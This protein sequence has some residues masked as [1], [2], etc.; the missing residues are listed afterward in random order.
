MILWDSINLVTN[1]GIK[2]GNRY[3]G[4][5]RLPAGKKFLVGEFDGDI[6]SIP[7]LTT[8]QAGLIQL[9]GKLYVITKSGVKKPYLV[10]L[11]KEHIDGRKRTTP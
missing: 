11:L 8:D 4:V 6:E 1:R 7:A 10:S 2:I 3:D 9:E 5:E